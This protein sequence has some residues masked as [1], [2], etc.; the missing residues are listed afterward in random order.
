MNN[1]TELKAH[2]SRNPAFTAAYN[3]LPTTAPQQSGNTI[4]LQ[5]ALARGITADQ[6]TA[7]ANWNEHESHN[8]RLRKARAR[9]KAQA[10]ALREVAGRLGQTTTGLA[11]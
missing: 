5:Q 1:V 8:Q 11:A 2:L 7:V 10:E 3:A 6:L 9:L 4:N